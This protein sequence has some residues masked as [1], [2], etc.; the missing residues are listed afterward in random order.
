VGVDPLQDLREPEFTL[1]DRRHHELVGRA[2]IYFQIKSVDE[3]KRVCSREGH[4]LDAVKKRVV[5]SKRFHESRGF[6]CGI[7]VVTCLRAKNGGFQQTPVSNSWDATVFVDLLLMDGEDLGDGKVD[8]LLHSLGQLPIEISESFV[9]A[10]VR[11]HY[12]RP[13][14]MLRGDNVV[15]VVVDG[16]LEEIS[17]GLAIFLRNRYKFLIELRVDRR[18][19]LE[20]SFGSHEGT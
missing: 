10:A 9:G 6:L 19:D 5:V 16:L 14:H 2:S 4:R 13:H 17:L 15:D 3:Q 1:G 7:R 12:F 18:A 11:R 8:A 20:C